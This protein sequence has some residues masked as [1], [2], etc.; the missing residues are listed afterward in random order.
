MCCVTI[1]LS[2]SN[3]AKPESD[4]WSFKST[5]SSCSISVTPLVMKVGSLGTN[6]SSFRKKKER[7]NTQWTHSHTGA[8]SMSPLLIQ[9]FLF[10]HAQVLRLVGTR[11]LL[12]IK[13]LEREIWSFQMF[14]FMVCPHPH[15][16]NP[17]GTSELLMWPE[18]S[19][20]SLCVSSLC[21]I[22]RSVCGA[23]QRISGVC[24][25][26]V[27]SSGVVLQKRFGGSDE[28]FVFYCLLLLL[29]T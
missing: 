4:T 10:A 18:H 22:Q 16:K 7:E 27:S 1:R 19:Y 23:A 13:L 24:L 15:P 3:E 14:I 21:S 6:G 26:C 2:W 20:A 17:N 8:F 12:N 9:D 29:F 11:L 28:W 5:H 25:V